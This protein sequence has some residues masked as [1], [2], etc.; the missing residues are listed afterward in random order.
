[1]NGRERWNRTMHFQSV[2]YIPDEEFGYWDETPVVWNQQGM[3]A[4][5]MPIMDQFFGFHR[6]DHV[7]PRFGLIPYF[8]YQVLEET[9]KHILSIN[10]T[11]VKHLT[12]KGP[13][14]S[15]PKY[16]EF[17]VKDWDT[18]KAYKERLDINHP[19]RLWTDEA[20]TNLKAQYD[21]RDFPLTIYCGS[22]FGWVRDWMGFEGVAIASV[23]E[24]DL[25]ED[26]IE[27]LTNM[28][29]ALIERPIK[30]IQFDSAAFW[31]DICFNKGPL[32]SPRMFRQ[33]MV[34]RYKKIT[35]KLKEHGVDVVY[36]DCDGNINELV[37][38]WLDSGVNTMFPI[39][40]RGGTDPVALREKYGN[41][42]LLMGGVDKTQLI[43]GK[44]AINKEISRLEKLV[45]GGGFIPHVD[46]RCPPDVTYENYL[47]Y[48]KTK[49]QAFGIP[50]PAPWEERRSQTK[51]NDSSRTFAESSY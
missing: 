28:T 41:R 44:S 43:A 21:N 16:Y 20:I 25:V 38:C 36:L 3:P 34:P 4:E 9:D 32:I 22:L 5:A 39:E 31:E 1:M 19:E 51:A 18:W 48:L 33:W 8:E 37:D 17:P 13:G 46:H 6:R 26:M 7:F 24:P 45:A 35:D 2:D 49:R 12:T 10:H 29:L 47:Y 42:V 27:H 15:I 30:E 14:G 11:G 40:V 50:E 23:E